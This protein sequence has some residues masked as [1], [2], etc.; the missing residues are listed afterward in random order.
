MDW[1]KIGKKLLFP[2]V[3]L[4]LL[5]SFASAT[6]LIVVFVRS[7]D[8]TPLA[9][10]VYVIAFYSLCVVSAF[11]IEVLPKRYRQIRQK[12]YAT[13]L[14]NRYLTDAAFRTHI[15]LYSS[16]CINLVYVGINIASFVLYRSMW[17]VVLASYYGILAVMRFL[18]VRYVR[19]NRIG[20][21]LLGEWKRSR[22]CAYILLT[23]N[24]TLSGAVLMILYQ[25]KGYEYHGMLIYVMA[26]YTFYMTTHAIVDIFKYR[27]LGSPV[28]TT[29]KIV[30]L[31]AALVCML[32]LETAMLSQFGAEMAAREKQILIA[33]TGG[34]VSIVVVAMSVLLIVRATKEIRSF[35][36][37]E[38]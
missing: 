27:R 1:K 17:F 20:D 34:G 31:S 28:M 38:S 7:L 16:L 23:V 36:H 12:I 25:N 32:S 15:S 30:T 35:K 22:I 21:S 33:A 18:M 11:C 8:E 5:L 14:G 24:L 3:W 19:K 2:P 29:A 37:E 26:M 9:Y 13:S 6:A 10:A 4:M